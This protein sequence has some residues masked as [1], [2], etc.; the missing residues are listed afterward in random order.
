MMRS[1]GVP[2][3]TFK[4]ESCGRK[5]LAGLWAEVLLG[6]NHVGWVRGSGGEVRER[7]RRWGLDGLRMSPGVTEWEMESKRGVDRAFWGLEFGAECLGVTDMNWERRPS[8]RGEQG[9]QW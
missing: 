8:A 2:Y 1:K 3:L 4:L 6:E 5:D 7:L 9:R